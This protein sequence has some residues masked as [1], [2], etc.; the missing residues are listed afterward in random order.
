MVQRPGYDQNSGLLFD[1]GIMKFLDVPEC[2]TRV[3][4]KRALQTLLKPLKEFP[5]LNASQPG[6]RLGTGITDDGVLQ[7]IF[8]EPL[9]AYTRAPSMLRR[10]WARFSPQLTIVQ[11]PSDFA[12][13][14]AYVCA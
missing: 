12:V 2:P 8:R 9:I 6:S 11:M 13:E 3:Q 4:A 14:I 7:I 10:K 1:A 5:F